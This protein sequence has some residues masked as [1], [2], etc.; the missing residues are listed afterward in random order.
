MYLALL[1]DEQKELFLG[2]AYHIAVLDEDYRD[3]EKAI[4]AGYCQEMKTTFVKEKMVKPIEYILSKLNSI[5]DKRVK[6]IIVFE[7]IGLSMVDNNY[8]DD[9]RKLVA[10]MET[11]FGLESGFAIKCESILNEYILFQNK[12]NQLIIE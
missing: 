4:I 6:K 9:E 2:L 7:A 11:L 12:I 5:S 1:S 8:D 3:A 10:R